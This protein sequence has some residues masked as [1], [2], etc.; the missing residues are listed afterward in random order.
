[1]PGT[2]ARVY[3]VPY[4]NM[5]TW[6]R[7][8]RMY[9]RG[10]ASGKASGKKTTEDECAVVNFG[11]VNPVQVIPVTPVVN[12]RI[13]RNN[14]NNANNANAQPVANKPTRKPKKPK[15]APSN[16]PLGVSMEEEVIADVSFVKV[17]LPPISPQQASIIA[18]VEHNNI[19]VDSVAG[20]GKTTT[21]MSMASAYPSKRFLLL[22]YNSDLR[23][24]TRQRAQVLG[25]SNIDVHT[26]HSLGYGYANTK[27]S[28]DTGLI[29]FVNKPHPLEIG[30]YDIIII[31]ECQDMRMILYR[32]TTH[33]IASATCPRLCV[34]GD[35]RQS[36]Y[37]YA[38][39]DPRFIT[40]ADQIWKGFPEETWARHQLTTSYRITRQIAAFVNY[41]MLGCTQ[42]NGL[43]VAVKDGPK[44]K[45]N[46]GKD[47]SKAAS[48]IS[49][50]LANGYAPG[51]IFILAPSVRSNNEASPIK[52]LANLL[53][54]QR[55]PIYI[56]A[57]DDAKLDPNVARGKI[58]FSSFHQSKGMERDAVLVLGCD[59]SY[60]EYFAGDESPDTCPN[61]Y[62]VAL[63]RA[64]KY[65]SMYHIA[66]K[67]PFKF[68]NMALIAQYADVTGDCRATD[69]GT[70][71]I[72]SKVGVTQLIRHM[73]TELAD[74][75]MRMITVRRIREPADV[76]TIP[77]VVKQVIGNATYAEE[78]SDITGV[79]IPSYY[80]H[81]TTGLMT[82]AAEI[83]ETPPAELTPDYILDIANKYNAKRS[84]LNFK[85]R[86]VVQYG[87]LT[88]TN[89]DLSFDRLFC[90]ISRM[91]SDNVAF[92]RDVGAVM[93]IP[94][95]ANMAVTGRLDVLTHDR[96]IEIKTVGALT[97]DHMIQLA[98]Y[99]YCW[100]SC[101][102]S[103]RQLHLYN[104]LT[105][106]LVE[107]IVDQDQMRMM[108]V[109]IIMAKY[110]PVKTSNDADWLSSVQAV[111][112]VNTTDTV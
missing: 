18:A 111:S 90:E 85:L 60:F 42:G 96:I 83:G 15:D 44:P 68:T 107:L 110:Y 3:I 6:I 74:A 87:W 45:Y 73:T 36:I 53:T 43:L 35:A 71:K 41:C 97:A 99:S 20:S 57:H 40:H 9:R 79:A 7:L 89:L 103:P 47:Y 56:P 55:I 62:Y 1:M 12:P 17:S 16:M 109:M 102:M 39:A 31:D 14:A 23:K 100:H 52:K 98:I 76:I 64:R 75:C 78:V 101:S 70:Y 28:T 29:K 105:D 108:I 58:I 86:Q 46:I 106:E 93:V 80:E 32:F 72:P 82:T 27:C 63:T 95:H 13:R 30:T 69:T 84:G 33:V 65:L 25:I 50:L 54:L 38:G 26:F 4:R 8:L 2:H 67:A 34:I 51:D 92:E 48:E 24:E 49:W 10:K 104:I 88:Q 77:L 19:I 81:I 61:T 59:S 112:T 37:G 66:S 22:T 21:S 11:P 91:P 94:G 5:N